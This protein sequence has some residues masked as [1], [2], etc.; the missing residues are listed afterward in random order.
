MGAAN[1]EVITAA[2]EEDVQILS[3]V[4][5]DAATHIHAREK[6]GTE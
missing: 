4:V 1:C 6:A 5:G 2:A 3:F